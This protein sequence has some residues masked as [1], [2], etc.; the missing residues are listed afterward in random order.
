MSSNPITPMYEAMAGGGYLLQRFTL[1]ACNNDFPDN[2][3]LYQ[4]LATAWSQNV[5]GFTRQAIAGNPWTSSFAAAQNGYY[6]PLTTTIPGGAAAVDVAW[7][8]F[9]NRLIQYLG[10]DQTPANPYHLPKAMLYQLAD[11]GALVNY[12]IPVT[13]CPQADWSGELKAYG[14]YGP[15]G[16]LDEYC[17]FSVARDARGKMVRIDFTCENPEYYQTLWSV[18][19]ERVAEVYTAALNFGAPQAQWVSVSV[20]DLQLVDPVTHKPVI[21]PQTGRPG[22]NPLNKWN[23][24]TVAMRAN[25]KFSGGA[26]HL[27]ATP[28]TLQT[29]LGLGAG[30]TVQRSSGNLDPQ[31]LICCG[32]FGQNYRNS[33]PH[34]G[35][36]INLAVGAGTNISLADPPGLYIQMPSFAQYQLPA[37]PKLPPGASAADC[38]HIVR[39]FETLIDPITKT[40]YPGSFIL[41]AAFQL[42]LAWVKAGVSF[43]L[44]DITIDGTPITCGSQV[45]ETFEVALFGRPIPPKAP[46][47]T[48]SCAES[49][50]VTKSQAQPLQIM[51]QPLWDAYY[52]TKFDTPVHQEMNLASNSSII[53]PTLKPGQSR[54]AL[55][56]TCSLPSG[57]TALPKEKWPKVLFTLPNGS[58]DTDINALVVDM[59]PNIKY[60]VPG[61]TYPDFAQLLKLEVSVTPRA[62]PGVRGVVIVPAGQTV[63]PA[64]PPAPAFLVIAQANQQ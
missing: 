21:D 22:Y 59:V 27:T 55:A 12:P 24:G 51:F 14:P 15:R 39:G 9:P 53:P 23:S 43:T 46:T 45:M 16:W 37:D 34:I 28:N 49:L 26:M 52:G 62:A 44:E 29:E 13:R 60:A 54:Q 64:I 17:E 57:E 25:G 11:T 1:P 2:P 50:P 6:N 35:Q 40:P 42:P 38:W 63:S 41:H 4:K 48:Q 8:A 58:I 7:I 19:P 47:P 36:T 33:D 3:V 10:Q 61:N 56:L 5:D 32:V 31:A 30:A 18:S 20:E